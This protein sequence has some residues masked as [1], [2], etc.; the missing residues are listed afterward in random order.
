MRRY[1]IILFVCSTLL[2][3]GCLDKQSDKPS[4]YEQTKKMVVDIL[5]TEEGKKALAE[6]LQDDKMKEYIVFEADEIKDTITEGLA[7]EQASDIWAQLFDDPSFVKKFLETMEDEQKK[8]YKDLM[9]DA[10]FQKQMIELLQNQEMTDLFLKV[11]RSQQFREHLEDT[12]TETLQSPLFEAKLME[13]L[14]KESEKKKKKSD[15]KSDEKGDEEK[16]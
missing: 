14:N 7:S 8:L 10:T 15:E 16:S 2:L 9:K 11:M 3:G 5:Q 4:D 1:L 6:I 12:I 13:F